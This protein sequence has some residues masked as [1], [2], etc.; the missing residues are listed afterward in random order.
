MRLKQLAETSRRPTEMGR[1][2]GETLLSA[3]LRWWRTLAFAAK[4]PNTLLLL[5]VEF[6][7]LYGGRG[8]RAGID[9]MENLVEA[10]PDRWLTFYQPLARKRHG[11]WIA[12]IASRRI[13]QALRRSFDVVPLWPHDA[14]QLASTVAPDLVLLESGASMPG[15][16]W[17]ALGTAAEAGLGQ[18]LAD[19]IH[20]FQDRSVP[21][22]FWW[23]TPVDVTA[24]LSALVDQCDWF[25]SDMS[26]PGVP[27]AP[28]LSLGVDLSEVEPLY[29]T[30][31]SATTQPLLHLGGYERDPRTDPANR[32]VEAAVR[33][34][35]QI[36]R[37]PS[38]LY[39]SNRTLGRDDMRVRYRRAS[40]TTPT[41]NDVSH[42]CLAMLASGVPVLVNE[43]PSMIRRI[44]DEVPLG[45]DL[46]EVVDV[47]QR[48]IGSP[49][50][51]AEILRTLHQYA[52]TRQRFRVVFE[53]FG[54]EAERSEADVIG[55]SVDGD[56][57]SDSVVAAIAEQSIRPVEVVVRNQGARGRLGDELHAAGIPVRLVAEP[58]A[59]RHAVW[60]GKPWY[61]NYLHD[62][63]VASQV[64][65]TDRLSDGKR[66]VMSGSTGVVGALPWW[67]SETRVD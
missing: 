29:P 38:H 60:T 56:S 16:A 44:V 63:L 43:P 19:T 59:A 10:R 22:A 67:I 61:K 21:V 57:N 4:H 49:K 35:A 53:H 9:G 36:M 12:V 33:A 40:W 2:F 1:G 65:A 34:R 50:G 64:A 3:M 27:D 7:R 39:P 51:M 48:R 20:G 13:V 26:V 41:T 14:K 46:L 18:L 28:P 24:D 47:A 62:L 32:L 11:P 25:V 37:E 55:V 54:I 17:S 52:T 42:R 5:P 58:E 66:I 23:T 15:E 31:R 30:E 6:S 8:Q 45:T